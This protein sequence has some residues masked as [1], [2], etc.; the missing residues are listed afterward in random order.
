MTQLQVTPA[1]QWRRASQEGEL[2]ELPGSG[3]VARLKRPALLALAAKAG[4]VPNLLAQE[5]LRLEGVSRTPKTEQEQ[6]KNYQEFSQ[7]YIEV[8]K[9]CFVEP[10]IVDQPNYDNGEIAVTDLAEVDL[11]WLYSTF[12]KGDAKS[13]DEFRA[14]RVAERKRPIGEQ[15]AQRPDNSEGAAAG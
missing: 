10:R 2:Y 9:L 13:R 3:M 15:L 8:A 14:E 11:F 6:I 7:G 12:I 4:T 5:V 1:S